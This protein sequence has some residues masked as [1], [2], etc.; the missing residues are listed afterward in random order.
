MD[1]EQ[2]ALIDNASP[3]ELEQMLNSEQPATPET[4]QPTAEDRK[5][6]V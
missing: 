2:M 3:E 6:V 5:S 1:S 4:E